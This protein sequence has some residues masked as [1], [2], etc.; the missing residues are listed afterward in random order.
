MNKQKS[1]NIDELMKA[2]KNTAKNLIQ[3]SKSKSQKK[4]KSANK[5]LRFTKSKGRQTGFLIG[6]GDGDSDDEIKADGEVKKKDKKEPFVSIRV[7]LEDGVVDE[8][9]GILGPRKIG[10]DINDKGNAERIQLLKLKIFTNINEKLYKIVK[11]AYSTD[12]QLSS[13][14]NMLLTNLT[15]LIKTL[16]TKLKDPAGKPAD[17]SPTISNSYDYE[18]FVDNELFKTANIDQE[19]NVL[20]IFKIFHNLYTIGRDD[21]RKID[22]MS[23]S[24]KKK[25][26]LIEAMNGGAGMR[27][28]LDENG[29][30]IVSNGEFVMVYDPDYNEDATDAGIS[31]IGNDEEEDDLSDKE[32]G[33][34]TQ[35]ID[36]WEQLENTFI[37]NFNKASTALGKKDLLIKRQDKLKTIISATVKRFNYAFSTLKSN[38]EGTNPES[39]EIDVTGLE[40]NKREDTGPK[41]DLSAEL[42]TKE[43]IKNY[44]QNI[45]LTKNDIVLEVLSV[46]LYDLLNIGTLNSVTE[47]NNWVA[48]DGRPLKLYHYGQREENNGQSIPFSLKMNKGL[49][50]IVED[51]NTKI[52]SS[53]KNLGIFKIQFK[54]IR[55]AIKKITDDV[56]SSHINSERDLST[57]T[58]GAKLNKLV[59]D[60]VTK[61]KDLVKKAKDVIGPEKILEL[62]QK[63]AI[64]AAVVFGEEDKD[65]PSGLK[66][67][68][69]PTKYKS[70]GQAVF[71]LYKKKNY[72]RTIYVKEKTKTK[73]CKINNEY[74]LLSKLKIIGQ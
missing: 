35:D 17:F 42:Y 59:T 21:T 32:E 53:N 26:G 36:N 72:K 47:A 50:K 63:P 71:I 52:G 43:E 22:R 31:E 19:I 45:Q 2:V 30:N 70:T 60:N 20:N 40:R 24:D 4:G 65:Q 57:A 56:Q 37:E 48:P 25:S 69:A 16:R 6:G 64:V 68:G 67:G 27:P 51:D 29:K 73:Y 62:E 33:G 18:L 74:I 44:L 8:I 15:T 9:G 10:E 49:K 3:K 23:L 66:T 55:D 7:K 39:V 1:M 13:E 11:A 34:I 58:S 28:Q 46:Y 41:R 5:I 14:E 12:K 38:K 61:Y 54:A